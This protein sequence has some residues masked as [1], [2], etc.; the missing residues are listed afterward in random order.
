[1]LDGPGLGHFMFLLVKLVRNFLVVLV[2]LR[3]AAAGRAPL[4]PQSNLLLQDFQQP[5]VGPRLFHEIRHAVLHGLHRQSHGRPPGHHHDRRCIL[6]L[7][8]VAE[9]VQSLAAR[10]R[11]PRVIQIHQQQVEFAL[12]Q[13]PEQLRG[14]SH[15][16]R[17]ISLPLEQQAQRVQ[18]IRLIVGNQDSRRSSGHIY[19]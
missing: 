17:F 15:R 18:H 8:Q 4:A 2:L 14:R 13:D 5:R 10:G 11:I 6:V 3:R 16:F 19:V 12:C 7:F 9:Q 1:M